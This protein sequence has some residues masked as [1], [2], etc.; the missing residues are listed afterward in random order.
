MLS[1]VS[2]DNIDA[3]KLDEKARIGVEKQENWRIIS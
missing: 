1:G 2:I 3:R